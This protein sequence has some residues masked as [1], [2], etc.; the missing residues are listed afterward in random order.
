VPYESVD[1]PSLKLPKRPKSKGYE[2]P[3]RE[4]QHYVPDHAASL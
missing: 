2:R 4:S 1:P 3:P